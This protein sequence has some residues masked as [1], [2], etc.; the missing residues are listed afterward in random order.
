MPDLG[1]TLVEL[2]AYVGDYLSYYQDAVATEA[3]LDTARQRISV[4]RHAR[5]VDYRMHEGCN[6]RA[7][8]TV[9]TDTDLDPS[10]PS[11]VYFITGFAGIKAASGRIVEASDLRARAGRLATRSSSRGRSTRRRSSRFCA[12]HSEIHFYT[13]GDHECC[14]PKGATRATLLDE[15]RAPTEPERR[16]RHPPSH[17]DEAATRADAARLQGGDVLIFE[18]VLGPT[19]GN[20]GRRRPGASPRRAPD[21][22][23]AMRY[24][25]LLGRHVLEIEWA[26]EDALPFP[27]C[28]SA[29]LP[30]PD[31]GRIDDVSVARGNVVLVDHGRSVDEP[32]GPVADRRRPSASARATAASSTSSTVP[33][34]F[35]AA[36]DDAPLTFAQPL[37]A[38]ARRQPRSSRRTRASRCPRCRLQRVRRRRV[39]RRRDRSGAPRYDLLD[40]GGDDRALRRR[41]RRRRRRAPA[42]RRRRARPAA[43]R[44]HAF[45]APLSHRQRTGRQRRRETITYLVLRDRHAERRQRRA[46]QSAA[47]ARRYRA[48]ADRRGRSC[49]RRVRF[50][51]QRE[52]AITADDYAELAQRN[53]AVQRAAAELRWTGSWYE[54]R[55]AVDPLRHR[56]CGSPRCSETIAATCSST[57]AWAT[58]SRSCRRA[59]CRSSCRCESACCR[60]SRAAH[61]KAALLEV[62]SNRRLRGRQRSASSIRTI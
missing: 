49:S 12:A 13:W 25:G 32:L 45:Q 16:S 55:V 6:A 18:E 51:R 50:A 30:A 43:R 15:R 21:Q 39:R 20:R 61:V 41:D 29:R 57:G 9:W 7:W 26:P 44:G 14:L 56:D 8:V 4:R 23:H 48:G 58:T 52:R 40:S 22:G 46:A 60:T 35:D 27:L 38:D 36:L 62:F 47:G 54:A 11:D 1:I 28:L 42:L 17:H 3:Y 19:T 24:D 53:P 33:E 37:P 10:R 2:L 5:L 59:T 34:R 31:C